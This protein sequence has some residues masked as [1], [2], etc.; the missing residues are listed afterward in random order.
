MDIQARGTSTE[1]NFVVKVREESLNVSGEA[2]F[3]ILGGAYVD[4]FV[5]KGAD[6]IHFRQL[7][8]LPVRE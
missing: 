5:D 3:S 6:G 8:S 7:Y 1:N 4:A 2:G